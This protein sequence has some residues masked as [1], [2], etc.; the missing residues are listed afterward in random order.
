MEVDEEMSVDTSDP[1][2]S[3]AYQCRI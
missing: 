3:R 1:N 2:A